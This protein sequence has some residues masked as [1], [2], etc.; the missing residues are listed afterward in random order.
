MNHTALLVLKSITSIWSIGLYLSPAPAVYRIHKAES[1]GQTQLIPFVTMFC[2]YHIWTMYSLFVDDLFPLFCTTIFAEIMAV[3]YTLVYARYAE[4][5]TQVLKTVGIAAIPVSLIT[6]YA[7][8]AWVGVIPQSNSSIGLVLGYIGDV[9]TCMF[10]ASPLVKI[11]TVIQTQSAACIIVPMCIMGGIGNALWIA[12]SLA[13]SNTFI[14]VPNVICLCLNALQVFLSFKYRSNQT[15]G[16]DN[17][18]VCVEIPVKGDER[19]VLSP[20][21][22]AVQSP[23]APVGLSTPEQRV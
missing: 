13:A 16:T 14:L 11:R 12:Y 6:L 3:V 21:Y 17:L 19:V 5:R 18:T 22:H 1:T 10:F 15:K 20:T 9:T 2:N 8:L 4:D 23:L 7:V